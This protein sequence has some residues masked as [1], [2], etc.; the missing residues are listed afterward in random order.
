MST[1][2]RNKGKHRYDSGEGDLRRDE[3]V[4]SVKYKHKHGYDSDE[5]GLR[6]DAE[7]TSS[8]NNGDYIEPP[9]QIKHK[10]STRLPDRHK[11]TRT[12]GDTSDGDKPDRHK[13]RST[14]HKS[15]PATRRS[16]ESSFERAKLKPEASSSNHQ[17]AARASAEDPAETILETKRSAEKYLLQFI[18]NAKADLEAEERLIR[19][20]RSLLEDIKKHIEDPL[21]QRSGIVLEEYDR[22]I[23]DWDHKND[24]PAKTARKSEKYLSAYLE[25]AS[26]NFKAHKQLEAEN[27]APADREDGRGGR[28]RK[29][30]VPTEDPERRRRRHGPPL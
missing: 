20:K 27:A 2:V 13:H 10:S 6:R 21:M 9:T 17:R 25:E 29:K 22:Y 15:K 26:R 12:T 8:E 1:P 11:S 30:K 24:A 14:R 18:E 19:Q 3:E 4:T 7:V 28:D 23:K 5:G 16:G